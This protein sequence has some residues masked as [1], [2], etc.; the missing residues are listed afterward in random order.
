L[1]GIGGARRTRSR[2]GSAVFI[3]FDAQCRKCH[4]TFEA[5]AY[6]GADAPLERG[7]YRC[8]CPKCSAPVTLR[9]EHG[10]LSASATGWAVRATALSDT[11]AAGPDE[12]T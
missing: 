10:A 5:E 7:Q 12:T 9:G 2:E 6:T 8:A 1:G 11:S 4:K 3:L